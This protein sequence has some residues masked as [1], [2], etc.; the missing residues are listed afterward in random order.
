[1]NP[2]ECRGIKKPARVRVLVRSG[3]F[4]NYVMAER[5]GF[6]PW[7]GLTRRRFSK[8]VLSATQSP[9]QSYIP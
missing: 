2:I 3:T 9:L 4:Q 8:P 6:E 1:M 7:D 5:Q